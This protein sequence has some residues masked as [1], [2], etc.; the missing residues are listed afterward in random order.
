MQFE[1]IFLDTVDSTQEYAKKNEK[2]FDK[3]KITCVLASEQT[4]GKGRCHRKWLSPTG[5][6]YLTFY[7]QLPKKS[8]HLTSIGHI[9]ALSLTDS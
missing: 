4:S 8:L 6:I 5:N 9:L 7:F 1:D 3:S 2:K